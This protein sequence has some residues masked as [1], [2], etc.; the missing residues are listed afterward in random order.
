MFVKTFFFIHVCSPTPNYKSNS[1]T[2]SS[3]LLVIPGHVSCCAAAAAFRWQ[4]AFFVSLFI[5]ARGQL[6]TC[7]MFGFSSF[8][9]LRMRMNQLGRVGRGSLARL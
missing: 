5:L 4:P 2:T 6:E 8:F 9:D 3:N 7:W 1:V